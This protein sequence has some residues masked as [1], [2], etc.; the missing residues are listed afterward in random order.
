MSSRQII[1][2]MMPRKPRESLVI[3]CIQQGKLNRR[4]EGKQARAD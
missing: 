3:I 2:Y 4:G 1:S